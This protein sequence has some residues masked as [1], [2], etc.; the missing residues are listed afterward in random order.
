MGGRYCNTGVYPGAGREVPATTSPYDRSPFEGAATLRVD[1]APGSDARVTRVVR[2][3]SSSGT[4]ARGG[5]IAR[6]SW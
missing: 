2:V 3:Q 6:A 5:G 1:P 4:F